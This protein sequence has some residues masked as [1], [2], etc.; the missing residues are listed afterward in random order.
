[1]RFSILFTAFLL[2]GAQ[3]TFAKEANKSL[4]GQD[5]EQTKAVTPEGVFKN[6][7]LSSLGV[8]TDFKFNSTQGTNYNSYKGYSK[9]GSIGGNN[10]FLYPGLTAGLALFRVETQL[11]S[12]ILL[13]PGFASRSQQSIR[14]NTLFG[15]LTKQV[16]PNF[17]VDLSGAYGRNKVNITSFLDVNRGGVKEQIGYANTYS[18]NWFASL[19]GLYT[20]TWSNR[21]FMNL[22]ARLLYTSI[23]SGTYSIF[24]QTAFPTQ[25]VAPLANK[26]WFLMENAEL[27][28]NFEKYPAWIPFVNAGLVQVLSYRNSRPLINSAINGISPQL[29]LDQNGYR[30]GTGLAYTNK[31]LTVRLEEQ[32]YNAGNI[33]RSYQTL[34]SV[35]YALA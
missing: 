13:N 10:I 15:H 8:Y 31:Q 4:Q 3:I 34:L 17:L 16:K 1:M 27:G 7:W 32:Y 11:S 9:L 2:V 5:E 24:Y 6:L 12:Q 19:M 30:L 20:K 33:F 25:T 14:N 29:N 35:K 18:T 26:S 23:E 22:N 28:Y 21:W